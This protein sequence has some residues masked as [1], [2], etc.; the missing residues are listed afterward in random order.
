MAR[1]AAR[2]LFEETGI[3]SGFSGAPPELEVQR[4]LRKEVLDGKAEFWP[5]AEGPWGL[6]FDPASYVP[7][8]RWITPHFSRARFNTNFFYVAVDKAPEPDVWPGELESGAWIDPR[9]AA[10]LWE[11][12]KVVL[13][14]P[15]LHTIRVLAEG[16]HGLPERLHE[17]P[18]ANGVPSRYVLVRPAITMVPLRSETLPPATHT[19]AIVVGDGDV[20]IVDPGSADPGELDALDAVVQQSL[21]PEGRV[22]A[23]LLTHRHRDH[24]AGVAATR[25]RY[26][27]PV[28]GHAECAERLPLDRRATP[29]RTSP[30]TKRRR[31]P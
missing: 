29:A 10:R 6:R 7:C 15:T 22:T 17:I 20:M 2:E 3:L 24:I 19:N 12:D 28:W 1:C 30:S 31:A 27:A 21:R 25:E 9:E 13:A 5:A 26:R 11:D 8:G 23:I 16:A 4:A 14:M 18:E